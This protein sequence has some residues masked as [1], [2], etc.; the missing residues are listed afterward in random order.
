[1][2]RGPRPSAAP[3]RRFEWFACRGRR[4][5]FVLVPGCKQ[6]GSQVFPSTPVVRAWSAFRVRHPVHH[7]SGARGARRPAAGRWPFPRPVMTF[8]GPVSWAGGSSRTEL[9]GEAGAFTPG[10]ANPP[11]LCRARGLGRHL[12]RRELRGVREVTRCRGAL[13][14]RPQRRWV[15]GRPS[16]AARQGA[17]LPEEQPVGRCP[18][19]TE[20][21]ASS[22]RGPAGV[23][24]ARSAAGSCRRPKPAASP[25]VLG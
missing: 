18:T 15:A 22:T 3:R 4:L 24:P 13:V 9:F 5:R 12:H 25:A 2:L 20:V 10:G 7:R 17:V 6:L 14:R 19:V 23:V 1:M 21:A 8:P 16:S 11:G